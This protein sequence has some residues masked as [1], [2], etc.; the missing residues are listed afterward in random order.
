M[1]LHANLKLPHHLPNDGSR[2]YFR[3]TLQC[4]KSSLNRIKSLHL[5]SKVIRFLSNVGLP[6]CSFDAF[7]LFL[8]DR[9]WLPLSLQMCCILLLHYTYQL[10]GA[11]VIVSRRFL[12][13]NIAGASSTTLNTQL[14][15]GQYKLK[16]PSFGIC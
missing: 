6:L 7:F 2:G 9:C 8:P 11:I 16:N 15:S 13:F 3:R 1:L 14:L 10:S 12:D 4:P 5:P